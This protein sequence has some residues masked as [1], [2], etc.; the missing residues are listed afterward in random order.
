MDCKPELTYEK[1]FVCTGADF[2]DVWDK[3]H[4]PIITDMKNR[5]FNCGNHADPLFKGLHDH[6]SVGIGKEPHY[7]KLY[8]GFV[9]EI[10]DT[11]QNYKNRFTGFK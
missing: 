11:Y 2:S 7:P 8:D 4:G 5:C 1:Y 9:K 3:I 10:N 6:V